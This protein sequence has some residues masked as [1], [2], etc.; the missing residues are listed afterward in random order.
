MKL[1]HRTNLALAL[2]AWL[3]ACGPGSGGTGTGETGAAFA[4]FGAT[5]ASVCTSGLAGALGCGPVIG[6][7]ASNPGIEV[8]SM[9]NF[10]NVAQGGSLS[11]AIQANSVELEDR[12]RNLRFTGD[13]GIT[14]TN[15]ARFFGSYSVNSMAPVI[16][17]LSVQPAP[18][19]NPGDLT[20]TLRD[21]S[22]RAVLGPVTLK[23]V[24]VLAGATLVCP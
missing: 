3:A 17:A 4:V 16:S 2:T 1:L 19:G 23:Q 18:S 15:D 12:C 8:P 5:A 13:W 20:V 24:G 9:V 21:A 7:P 10:S 22:G 6:S 11:V 14:A